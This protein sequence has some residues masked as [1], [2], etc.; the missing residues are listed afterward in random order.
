[1]HQRM[2]L[3]AQGAQSLSQRG[4]LSTCPEAFRNAVLGQAIWRL[5][6]PGG[7][8]QHAG[9]ENGGLCGIARGMVELRW[10]QAP[11][12]IS[13]IHL[14]HAGFWAGYRPLIGGNAR[15]LTVTA[16]DEVLYALIPQIAMERLLAETPLWWRHV[17]QLVDIV[18]MIAGEAMADLLLHDSRRRALATLLRLVGCRHSD[19][20]YDG[21]LEL[22]IS[23]HDLAAMANMTRNTMRDILVPYNVAGDIDLSYRSI[24][25]RRPTVLRQIVDDL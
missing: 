1:M 8:L 9:G 4:W 10:G 7:A 22:R 21:P 23:Q 11:A 16:R 2:T 3:A 19:P 25:V 13:G 14:A 15:A 5:V 6:K 12:D 24:I 18:G 17:A 20:P